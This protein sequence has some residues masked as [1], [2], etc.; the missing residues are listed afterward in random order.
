MRE[1]L[2]AWVALF[3]ALSGTGA[4]AANT[5]GTGDIIDDQVTSADVRDD[6]LAFGGLARQ[7]LGA[8]SV[9]TS[10][11]QDNSIT[12]PDI[13]D[14]SVQSP[15]VG[16][17][18]LTG[19]D[20]N[21]S[22]LVMPPTTTG[23]IAGQG[24]VTVDSNYTKVTSKT[25]PPG[26]YAI[27]AT[28]N[29]DTNFFLGSGLDDVLCELRNPNGQFIGGGRES[30]KFHAD[31]WTFSVSMNGLVTLGSSGEVGL[32]CRI[33]SDFATADGQMLIIRLEGTF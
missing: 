13:H 1:N 33:D 3:F 30:H 14:G 10:E 6:T 16:D 23:A 24:N 32:Y 21:E 12:S 29:L 8:G 15:D 17:N 7:D 18:A 26:R 19:T 4:Y 9:S 2:F 11:I 5:I 20:I 27:A 22:T 25:L 28:A 31:T